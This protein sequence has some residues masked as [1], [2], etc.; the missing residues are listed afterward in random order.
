LGFFYSNIPFCNLHELANDLNHQARAE[1]L[2]S[3]AE[4]QLTKM[5]MTFHFFF[6]FFSFS[7]SFSL[8][9]I[10]M[11]TICCMTAEQILLIY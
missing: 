11:T 9:Y 4:L 2:I 5:A 6:S 3:V 1:M 8:A 7:S 10:N